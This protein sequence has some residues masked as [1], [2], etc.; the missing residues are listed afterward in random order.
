MKS[1]PWNRLSAVVLAGSIALLG[2]ASLASAQHTA[3]RITRHALIIG[4]GSYN[5]PA[6]TPLRGVTHDVGNARQMAQNMGVP[7]ANVRVLQD[8]NA[9]Y[10]NIR[11]ELKALAERVRDG[12]RVFLYFSGHGTRYAST[13]S[14]ET[15]RE[16]LIPADVS[17]KAKTPLLTQ[18]EIGADLAPAY[19]KADKVFVF[20][21]ACHSGG[22]LARTRAI[23]DSDGDVLTPKFTSL[24]TPAH[25]SKPSN[26]RKR[27]VSDEARTRGAPPNNVVQLSSSRPDEISLDSPKTGGLATNA[28][29]YCSIYADDTDGSGTLSVAEIAA[30]VQGK[31]D[32]RLQGER[33][34]TGQHLVLVG[35]TGYAPLQEKPLQMAAAS[36]PPPTVQGAPP[37]SANSAA[38]PPSLPTIAARP[39]PSPSVAAAEPQQRF[40]LESVIAQSDARHQVDVRQGKNTL[41]IGKDFLELDV[42]SSRGGYLYL[43]LQSS[44]NASTYILF[45]NKLDSGNRIAAQQW[46]RVPRAAWRMRSMGPPGPNRLL[47][48]V[49]DSP[50]DL[51]VLQA[52]PDGPFVKTLSDR[53]ASQGLSWVLGTSGAYSEAHCGATLA[54]KDLVYVEQC[55]DSFGATL[56]QFDE[57]L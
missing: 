17:I 45:P 21:D 25:C 9:T 30:C 14:S 53:A 56:V 48:M 42:K 41:Q 27:S 51:T 49:T 20:F 40:P 34:Y 13:D 3:A 47:V 18:E 1:R 22:V 44:D 32:T 36:S 19:S 8:Q 57:R 43:I 7:D 24:D 26:V 54:R 46:V 28:W 52:K 23:R 31:I 16:A 12:D 10:A 33:D 2:G 6:V 4:I 55:S 29:R 39:E 11:R 37:P 38:S 15:C 5:D 35:N 50:R